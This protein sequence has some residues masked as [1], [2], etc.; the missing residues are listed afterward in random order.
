VGE[1]RLG[2]DFT[3]DTTKKP[4][5]LLTGTLNGGP[6]RLADLG[7]AV[8]A[9]EQPSRKGRVLPDRKFDLPSLQAMDARVNVSLSQL[10]LGAKS[11]APLA[12]VKTLLVLDNGTLSLDN[13]N[14]GIAGGQVAGNMRLDSNANP[15][16]WQARAE[17]QNMAIEQWFKPQVKTLTAS[18]ITGRMRADLNVRGRGRST[19]EVLGTLDGPIWLRLE[20]GS[21]SHLLTEAAG[22]DVAQ[23]LG[24]LIKGD[25]NLPLDCALVDGRFKGGVLRPRSAVMDNKDSRIDLD[26]QINLA[27][28]TLALRVVAKP[29]D[30][31]PLTLRAPLRVEGTLA[32][33]RVA[34]EGKALGG[35]AIAAIALGALAP[36]AAL[37]AFI[38]PGEDVPP[39]NCS[40]PAPRSRPTP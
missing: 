6:L 11:L 23:G 17:V 13:F 32:D 12:P 40:A 10:D 14:A 24:M 30:F 3:F 5:S 16:N 39:L 27:D 25:S 35:R 2:G 20:K 28:E 18:P 15:P 37:L 1:S 29:K 34:L 22:L 8:G 4:R 26:G 38:D 31:S 9:D 36:P 33:P 7:P 21:V 19:A